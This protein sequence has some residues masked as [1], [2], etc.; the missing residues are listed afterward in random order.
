YGNSEAVLGQALRELGRQGAMRVV[1]K[2][3]HL[4]EAAADPKTARAAIQA[5]VARSRERLQEDV[6]PLC[7]FHREEDARYLDVLADLREQGRLRAFGCSLMTPEALLGLVANPE[8]DAVQVPLSVL[9]RR[10]IRSGAVARAAERGIAVFA[11]SVFVQGLL[12]LPADRVPEPLGELLPVRARLEALAE[13][14]GLS[15]GELALRAVLSEPG[16]RCVVVGAEAELQVRESAAWA[17]RGALEPALAAAVREAV[18]EL[19]D[20]LVVPHRWPK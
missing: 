18:P 4:R 3:A 10:F 8:L 14:A 1:T 13:E 20:R 15:L 7:L 11:R 19:P 16:V 12:L 17:A 5:S 2:V 9:D 6:L